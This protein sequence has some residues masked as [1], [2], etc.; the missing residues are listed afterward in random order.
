MTE[1]SFGPNALLTPHAA[2][3]TRES[4]ARMS[5]V[6]AE[7]VVRAL[8]GEKPLNFINPEAWPAAQARRRA[9]GHAMPGGAAP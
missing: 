8:R 5:T 9:L 1:H 4:V 2:G 3:L 6:S 7:E